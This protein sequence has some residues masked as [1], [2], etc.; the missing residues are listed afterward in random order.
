M[1]YKEALDGLY[2]LD[3]PKW[4]FGLDRIEQLLKKLGNP[5]KNLKCIHVAGTNGKGSVC[6]MLHSVLM[7]AGYKTGLYTSPHLKK[8]NER[9]KINNY[10]ISDKDIVKYYLKVKKHVDGQSFFEITTA[11]AFLYFA[12]KNADFVVLEVGL[13]GRL[14]ATNVVMPMVSIITNIGLEHTDFLGNTIEKISYEKAGIIKKS[15]PVVTAAEGVAL[16]AIKKIS[17]ERTS[18][19]ILINKNNIK[20]NKKNSINKDYNN[21]KNKIIVEKNC[22]TFDF[23]GYKNIELK[24]L[25]GQF[26]ALNAAIAIKAIDAIKNNYNFKINENNVKEGLLNAKWPGRFQFIATNILI[27]SAHNPSGFKVL[28]NEL[29]DINYNKLILIVGFSNDKDIK[30]ISEIIKNKAYKAIITKS[31]NE[32]ALEPKIIK[33]YFNKNSIIIE[34]PK[35]ALE[36]AKDIAEKRDLILITGSIFLVGELM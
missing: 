7:D 3:I 12:E 9:I 2:S 36:Y 24:N 14:D 15:V 6:A 26:Q 30:T 28:A 19:L 18:P 4:T 5:E 1:D 8:F 22:W 32:R 25:N 21:K 35:K 11:M 20:Y 17:N 31:G 29:K 27:D 33:K 13:G 16:A 10:I 34:N 23:N